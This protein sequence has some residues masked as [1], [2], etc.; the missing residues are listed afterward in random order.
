M[1][2]QSVRE[3]E[4]ASKLPRTLVSAMSAAVPRAF[5]PARLE[6]VMI[7][8][9]TRKLAPGDIEEVLKWLNS[10]LGQ[11]CTRLEEAAS[12]PAV[13]ADMQNY[14]ARLKASPPTPERLKVLREFDSAVKATDS[15]VDMALN[16]Q[17]ALALAV[18][19]T[20][21]K[22]QQ[23]PLDAVAREME[24]NRPA[25]EANVRSQVLISHLYTYR[26]LSDDEIRLYTEFAKSPAGSK[27]HVS[28]MEAFK[29]ATLEGAAKWGELIGKA[30]KESKGNSEA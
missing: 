16:T 23:M 28:T 13:Q 15:A 21:P 25:L 22:E 14:A 24:K 17:V 11:K 27:Y 9:L 5:A 30:I 6:A 4:Q 26:S 12:T 19:A 7:S 20:F 3:D 29:K 1:F 2:D 18:I 8:E 10:P